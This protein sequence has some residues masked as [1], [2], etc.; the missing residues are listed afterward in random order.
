MAAPPGEYDVHQCDAAEL[1]GVRGILI[2]ADAIGRGR[3]PRRVTATA[4]FRKA[5]KIED[6]GRARRQCGD[7]R[8]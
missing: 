2:R 7:R 4:V 6:V 8:S 3:L 5:G 1:R